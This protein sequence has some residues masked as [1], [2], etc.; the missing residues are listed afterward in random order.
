MWT[1]CMKFDALGNPANPPE[2]C[3][4]GIIS[5]AFRGKACAAFVERK[6]GFSP[7]KSAG[8]FRASVLNAPPSHTERCR[9]SKVQKAVCSFAGQWKALAVTHHKA[10]C[11]QS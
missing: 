2:A 8:L 5:S 11:V 10:A 6:R 4:G 3:Q 9:E 1:V 7:S